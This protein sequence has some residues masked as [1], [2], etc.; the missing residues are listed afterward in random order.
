[1]LAFVR[2]KRDIL[3]PYF[4]PRVRNPSRSLV[5]LLPRSLVTDKRLNNG[6]SLAADFVFGRAIGSFA[7]L[8]LTMMTAAA[9]RDVA[10]DN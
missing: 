7:A 9:L 1:M 2:E 3:A 10:E 4:C 6:H 5:Q 8:K